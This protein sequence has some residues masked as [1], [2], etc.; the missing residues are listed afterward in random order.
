MI[1][2]LGKVDQC[3]A[4]MKIQGQGGQRAKEAEESKDQGT[5]GELV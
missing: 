2:D 3:I 4:G 5:K 1:K